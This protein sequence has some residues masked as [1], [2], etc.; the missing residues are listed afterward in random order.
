MTLNRIENGLDLISLDTTNHC[1]ARCIFCFN[2]WDLF[3][4]CKMSPETFKK[5]LPILSL[6]NEDGQFLV[7]CWFEPTLNR[8]FFEI[9][10]MIPPEVKDRAFF[11][12]NLV[13][14]LRDEDIAAMCRANVRYINVSLETYNEDA[15]RK[16]TNV[17]GGCFYENLSRLAKEAKKE[18]M[19]IRLLSMLL[20]SNRGEFPELVRRAHE[21]IGPGLHEIRTPFYYVED[22]HNK[23]SVIEELLTKEEIEETQAAVNA[24]GY[25]HVVWSVDTTKET[26]LAFEADKEGF[27]EKRKEVRYWIRINADGTARIGHPKI[28]TLVNLLELPDPIPVIKKKLLEFRGF[29]ASSIPLSGLRFKKDKCA[30]PAICD[31]VNHHD[32]R[33]LEVTGWETGALKKKAG[34]YERIIILELGKERQ[35]AS[36]KDIARPDVAEA[37]GDPSISDAGF[38]AWFDFDHDPGE[39]FRLY[40]GYRK[41]DFVY[42]QVQIYGPPKR[43][44]FSWR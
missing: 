12:T 15:Y 14:P 1:N 39:D 26:F 13:A 10:K 43:K 20:K 41:G 36:V 37:L 28:G 35:V 4:P 23:A 17:R 34:G 5:V 22:T 42:Q 9:L 6:L 2:D 3:K 33:F 30:A 16:I 38:A 29:F 11:T 40:T 32:G 31:V 21:E 19:E 8:D 25:A 44:W 27:L 18:G 24:L 7:S